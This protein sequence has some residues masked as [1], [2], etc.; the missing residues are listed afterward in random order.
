MWT[1]CTS[2]CSSIISTPARC[3]ATWRRSVRFATLEKFK[4]GELRL[5]VC[6]DVAARGI[7]IGGSVA[8]VQFRRAAPCRGLRPPHRPHRPRRAGR[9]GLHHRHAG[10]P[11]AVEA[12]EKLIAAP[13]PP[14]SSRAGP[15]RMGR[16]RRPQA[17]PRR[18]ASRR[19]A[20][21]NRKRAE[22][23]AQRRPASKAPRGTAR[24]PQQPPRARAVPPRRPR[25]PAPR[26]RRGAAPPRARPGA[27]ARAPREPREP[28]RRR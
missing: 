28:S 13:I 14:M 11:L 3:M 17:R 25:P 5:L 9:P 18:A 26:R 4:A 6:S 12:I 22:A 16:G 24:P 19:Q 10:R 1:S 7:D 15:G 8:C 20:G 23:E 27:A 21:E 2:R